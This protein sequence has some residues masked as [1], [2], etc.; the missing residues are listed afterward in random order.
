LGSGIC[1]IAVN[2]AIAFIESARPRNELECSLAIQMAANHIAALNVLGRIGGAHG[3]ERSLAIKAAAAAR[4]MRAY[5]VQVDTLR[6]LR[7]AG[8]EI[9]DAGCEVV[10]FIVE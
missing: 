10:V 3:G 8:S 1:E 9:M 5:A 2:A 6:R 4:L 7:N